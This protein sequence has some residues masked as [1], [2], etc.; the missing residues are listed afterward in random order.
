M[1]ARH[2]NSAAIRKRRLIASAK[3]RPRCKNGWEADESKLREVERVEEASVEPEDSSAKPRRLGRFFGWGHF[4]SS[5][6]VYRV[7]FIK[8]LAILANEEALLS[9][10]M[11]SRGF[12][13]RRVEDLLRTLAY[14][15]R[16]LASAAPVF[17]CLHYGLSAC[18]SSQGD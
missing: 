7:S 15:V 2:V 17:S 16:I 14:R 10:G 9:V 12:P 8:T 3:I 13:R 11:F 1:I 5:N 6:T 4:F 18:S